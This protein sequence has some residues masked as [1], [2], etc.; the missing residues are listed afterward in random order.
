MADFSVIRKGYLV[1]NDIVK[2]LSKNGG[3]WYYIAYN[4]KNNN[5]KSTFGFFAGR[6]FL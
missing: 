5:T 6:R 3:G 2:V 4:P 1:K